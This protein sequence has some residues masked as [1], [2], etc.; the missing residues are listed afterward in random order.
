MK[1]KALCIAVSLLA[2]PG[3]AAAQSPFDNLK[4]A[5]GD[6]GK[7]TVEKRV[8]TK[9]LEEG[10]K[11]QC[12]FKTGTAELAAGCED[13]LKKLT[14]ALIDAKKQLT[15]GGVKSYKFEVSGHTDSTGDAAKNK[16]LSEQ[17]AEV[18]V[19]ELV[20]RGLPR[21]EIVAV[22][23][24][25]DRPLVKPDNTEAKKAKNRRYELQVRL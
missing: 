3:V 11:N 25:S 19:K 1:L 6:A 21:G 9:L 22:G 4:K 12:S 16:K 24:G 20:A 13:K 5:A 15:A 10:Q 14:N 2:I 7:S 18:I 8:N 23:L 17:R